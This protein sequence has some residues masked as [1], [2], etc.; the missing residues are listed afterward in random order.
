MGRKIFQEKNYNVS[1]CVIPY[2]SFKI[3]SDRP[4]G[5]LLNPRYKGVAVSE[6]ER[7]LSKEYGVLTASDFLLYRRTGNRA[8]YQ[9]QFNPRRLDLIQ[10]TLAEAY[11]RQ[12]RFI[13]KILDLVWM[14]L[15]ESTWVLPA[16]INPNPN[17]KIHSLPYSYDDPR[18]YSDLYV[19]NTGAT[20]AFTWYVCKDRFDEISPVINER[21]VKNLKD[22]VINPFIN[23]TD[24]LAWMGNGPYSWINNWCPHIVAQT[25][26][27]CALA[28]EDK[29]TRDRVV[30]VSLQALDKFTDIYSP[31]GAC[32]E[33][34]GYWEGAGGALYEACLVIYDMTAGKINA[35]EDDLLRS[36]AEYFSAMYVASGHFLNY[37]DAHPSV[38]VD[39]PWGYDWGKMCKSELMMNF[40][41][42]KNEISDKLGKV[43][44]SSYSCWRYFRDLCAKDIERRDFKA[45]LRSYFPSLHLA[46][47]RESEVPEEGLYLSLKGG[48]NSLSHN[49]NDTGDFTVFCD[50]KPIF[51]DAGVGT[52]TRRTFD[53]DRY[54]I[55]SMS[56]EYHNIPT[57]NGVY[58]CSGRMYK[59]KDAI[60]DE[61]SGGL[62][63]DLTDAYKSD[64]EIA[65]YRRAA[66]IEDGKAVVTDT[67]TSKTDGEVI[68]NLLCVTKPRLEGEGIMIVGGKTVEF[69]PSL[70]FSFDIPDCSW[71]ETRNLPAQ[72]RVEKFYRIRLRGR[73]QAGKKQTFILA[74]CK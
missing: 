48:H 49:H 13:D 17:D 69:D 31:D 22:R 57:I 74:V 2:E 37:S 67:I 14:I 32:D 50:G 65:E 59:S 21:I 66:V 70:E 40:W 56:G 71:E 15:E 43:K 54:T 72:W 12:G 8:I 19:G 41:E 30:E 9:D 11:E 24:E 39:F 44:F 23:H 62:S 42:F 55:W 5:F 26:T 27:V 53:K 47:S 10:L 60:Y 16:H 45:A 38:S 64:A 33:G 3:F 46:V 63:I 35:F 68:F 58:Q 61:M 36:M 28:I 73:L 51:V 7:L 1:E 4:E 29:P 18:S 6:A 52:Y 34:P 25:L 20:L